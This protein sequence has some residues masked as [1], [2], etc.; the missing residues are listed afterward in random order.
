VVD[1]WSKIPD[2]ISRGNTYDFGNF[3]QCL[4]VHHQTNQFAS[5][6]GQHC[7]FQFSSK[8]NDTIPKPPE[9][10][11]FNSGWK[12]I[13]ERFGS[14]ICLPQKCS[15]EDVRKVIRF[16]LIDTNFEIANDYKQ[17]DFCK[18]STEQKK[19]K[20]S[21]VASVAAVL[22]SSVLILSTVYDFCTKNKPQNEWFLAFSIIKNVKNLM[23]VKSEAKNEV[24]C[25]YFLRS[26]LAVLMVFLHIIIFAVF[27]PSNN[28]FDLVRG[29]YFHYVF[30][31]SSSV[32][33]FFVISGFLFIQTIMK[34][35]KKLVLV[36]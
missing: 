29:T 27:Y 33:G 35:V 20:N 3:D 2:K 6:K 23:D 18:S 25:F 11:W 13:D 4:Q 9:T 14:A 21:I 1:S 16:L 28:I 30:V 17:E 24:K 31:F 7:M 26:I 19:S 15:G 22:L 32:N 10:S 12:H 36:G 34:E 5:I 8:F